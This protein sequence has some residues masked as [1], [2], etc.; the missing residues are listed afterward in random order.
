MKHCYLLTHPRCGTLDAE[1]T[2]VQE[3]ACSAMSV[4]EE[5]VGYGLQGYLDPIL[6]CVHT[7]ACAYRLALHFPLAPFFCSVL[8]YAF[9]L[10]PL[11][12]SFFGRANLS[13]FFARRLPRGVHSLSC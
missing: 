7:P 3:A 1:R 4:M 13:F 9:H 6:R 11:C 2:Q 12:C 10:Y 5:E 8:W